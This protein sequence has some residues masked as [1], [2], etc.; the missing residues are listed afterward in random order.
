MVSILALDADNKCDYA[1]CTVQGGW[2]ME[3]VYEYK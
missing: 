1:I 3:T 2:G